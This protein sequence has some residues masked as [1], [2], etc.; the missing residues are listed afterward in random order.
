M[1]TSNFLAGILGGIAAGAILG[2][3]FAPDKGTETR[4]KIVEKGNELAGNFKSNVDQLAN[5]LTNNANEALEKGKAKI[6]DL[7]NQVENV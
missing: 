6:A 1:K 4:R 7:K 2:V 5:D 3:L